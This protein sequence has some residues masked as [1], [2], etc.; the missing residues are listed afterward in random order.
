MSILNLFNGG[1]Y[2]DQP[3]IKTG[4]HITTSTEYTKGNNTIKHY[5]DDAGHHMKH[6]TANSKLMS[7][8]HNGALLPCTLRDSL[9]EAVDNVNAG[10]IP[11]AKVLTVNNSANNSSIS[12][13]NV[14]SANDVI[15]RNGS[16][17]LTDKLAT[18]DATIS[19]LS[20][21]G[22]EGGLQN[23]SSVLTVGN[24]A[25]DK[26]MTVNMMTCGALNLG[27][28]IM[29]D[30]DGEIHTDATI[31]SSYVYGNR[32]DCERI[33]IGSYFH[34]GGKIHFNRDGNNS[35]EGTGSSEIRGFGNVQSTLVQTDALH[36][37]TIVINGNNNT[38]TGNGNAQL[39]GFRNINSMQSQINTLN[40]YIVQLQNFI[41]A[42]KDSIYIE[43]HQGSGQEYNYDSILPDQN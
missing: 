24:S 4:N 26:N 33:G 28:L 37:G 6:M 12:N 2:I 41:M 17:S 14:I 36:S 15:L 29:T 13:V 5:I 22:G 21:G 32:M 42:F 38:I 1:S 43:S 11:L 3:V 18:I 31:S 40:A 10:N 30:V 27:G 16:V 19:G 35:I 20:G 23:L 9:Y 34:V 7:F 39:T 8:D 25:P